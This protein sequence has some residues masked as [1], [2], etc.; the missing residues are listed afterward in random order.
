MSAAHV[1]PQRMRR[2]LAMNPQRRNSLLLFVACTATF[3][4]VFFTFKDD[5]IADRDVGSGAGVEQGSSTPAALHALP[6]TAPVSMTARAEPIPSA[7]EGTQA[8]EPSSEA[9]TDS[10][11][12]PAEVSDL[13]DA[14][15][16]AAVIRE[17]GNAATPGSLNVLEQTVRSDEVVRNRLLA[18]NSLRLLAKHGDAGGEIRAL[19]RRAMA[20]ADANVATHARDAYRE[21]TP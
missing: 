14:D 6:D 17:L 13:G 3:L 21:L 4:G 8:A 2:T 9:S 7:S 1:H 12:P 15:A 5:V 20:D 16:R 19:L 11:Q 18:V 10:L